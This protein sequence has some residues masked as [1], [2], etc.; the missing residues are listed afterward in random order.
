MAHEIP[1]ADETR[2]H[3]QRANRHIAPLLGVLLVQPQEFAERIRNN[4]RLGRNP[5]RLLDCID[6]LEEALGHRGIEMHVY[7]AALRREVRRYTPI[8]RRTSIA[9][10]AEKVR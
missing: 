3:V 6:D 2:R 10:E 5:R 7:F 1:K 8:N 4:I 9:F